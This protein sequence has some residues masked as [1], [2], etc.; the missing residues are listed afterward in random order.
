MVN[1]PRKKTYIT[2]THFERFVKEYASDILVLD[3]YSKRYGLPK[4]DHKIKQIKE[5]IE[6]LKLV[7][8]S[9]EETN[10]RRERIEQNQK[11]QAWFAL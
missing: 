7:V 8:E 9:S 5:N 2:K 6:K 11:Q 1:W 4:F 10:A 3:H